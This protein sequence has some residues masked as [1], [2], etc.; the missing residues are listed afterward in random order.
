MNAKNLEVNA[1]SSVK[2]EV[3]LENAQNE[4]LVKTQPDIKSEEF[5]A[6]LK[7]TVDEMIDEEGLVSNYIDT[8]YFRL[9]LQ[10]IGSAS[11]TK[12]GVILKNKAGA[13]EGFATFDKERNKLA[14]LKK[15]KE[16]MVRSQSGE[17]L[18]DEDLDMDEYF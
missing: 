15:V 7:T 18:S 5:K 16:L 1:G 3:L 2:S 8:P 10:I 12:T 17:Q 9:N 6:K 11:A 13:I 4:S 14:F